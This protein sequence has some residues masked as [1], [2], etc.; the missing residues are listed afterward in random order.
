MAEKRMFAKSII[1]SDAFL[2]M[3]MSTQALYFHLSMRAD[4]DGFIDSPRKIMR[5]VG[6]AEDDMRLLITKRYILTF[7]SGVIVIKHW[8]LHNYIRKDRY[9]ETLYLSEKSQLYLKDNGAYTDHS[10]GGFYKPLAEGKAVIEK[11][12]EDEE[13]PRL[14]DG[15]PLVGQRLTQIRL[16]KSSIDK[17][18]LDKTSIGKSST[19]A[20]SGKTAP[21]PKEPAVFTLPLNDGSEHSVTQKD[22]DKYTS[23]YPAVD[24]MQELRNM[25][26]WLDG[27]PKQRKTKGGIKRFINSWL[28]RE[29][30]R[31]GRRNNAQNAKAS[32]FDALGALNEMLED[33][34]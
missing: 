27:N 14:P 24:I 34:P 1:D 21:A 5:I 28:A 4:D 32:T 11:P 15:Q 7:E 8:R 13:T 26:G 2:S 9:K 18:S 6:A 22:I 31:G 3:P 12:L 17:S 19:N 30:N 16:D 23:L 29:Q 25:Y 20:Q 33:D 10:G